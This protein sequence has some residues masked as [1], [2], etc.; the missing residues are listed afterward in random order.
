MEPYGKFRP[1]AFDAAGAFLPDRQDWL[2][3]PTSRTRDSGCL[4]ESN[5]EA[6]RARL[7]AADPDG[8]DHELHRFGHW[9]PGWFELLIVRPGTN[10]ARVG[11]E[12]EAALDN[13]PVLDEK[14]FSR[15]EWEAACDA[16]KYASADERREACRKAGIPTRK[17]RNVAMP[18]ECYDSF[19][20][21]G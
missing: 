19:S 14:D 13:Y 21:H 4:A 1:T 3:V 5:F 17:A 11:A 15:R 10:A 20:P 16:W 2:V 9:G 8:V 6:A 12:I 18:S 7:E